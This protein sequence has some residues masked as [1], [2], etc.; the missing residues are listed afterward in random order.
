M[1]Y[2]NE[3]KIGVITVLAILVSALFAFYIRGFRPGAPTYGIKVKFTNAR[4]LQSGDPVRMVGVRIGEVDNVGISPDQKAVALLKL[5]KRYL[6]HSNDEFRIGT[7]GLI[8]ERFVEVV[9][10]EYSPEAAP[11]EDGAEV[12]G[13]VTPD[14]SDLFA[15]AQQ[16]LGNLDRTA[17][18]LRSVLTDKEVLDGIKQAL[19]SFS[20]S[21]DA[22]GRLAQ[23]IAQL[24]EESRPEMVAA[25]RELRLAAD[26]LRTTTATMG[27][28]LQESTALDDLDATMH[29][30]REAAGKAS[31]L[32][33]SLSALAAD[34]QMQAQLRETISVAHDAALGIKEVSEDLKTF[35]SELRKAA[36]A[37]PNVAHEAENIAQYSSTLRERLK[38]PEIN[39]RFDVLYSGK[40][41]RTFSSGNLDIKTS[42]GHFLRLGIDDIGEDSSANIQLGEQQKKGILRYG[43]VRSRLGLGLDIPVSRSSISIDLFDPNNVRAD[44]LADVPLILGRSDLGLVAGVRDLGE[45]N[46]LVAGVRLRR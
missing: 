18:M 29:D 42:E 38:P 26:D 5:D 6:V 45:D 34:P 37:V 31:K 32:A 17:R 16:V 35:S 15:S 19:E 25:L 20:N 11:L 43:L 14:L 10:G 40:A 4:G 41:S 23:S 21:A 8:Q 9:P 1:R 46:L 24:S 33:D 28:R 39:A 12:E 30:A 36:P 13:V 27:K 2:G 22:A 3:V 44:I 7:S